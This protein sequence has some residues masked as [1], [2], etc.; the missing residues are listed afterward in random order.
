M[1]TSLS[2]EDDFLSFK[3]DQSNDNEPFDPETVSVSQSDMEGQNIFRAKAL[4]V[5]QG[6]EKEKTVQKAKERETRSKTKR[7]ADKETT[8]DD[9]KGGKGK[10]RKQV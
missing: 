10:V 7:K 8:D 9:M 5:R 6:L 3:N 4:S 2:T 1:E